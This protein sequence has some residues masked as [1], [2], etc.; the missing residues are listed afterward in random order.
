MD[1]FY[2]PY[3][4]RRD[5]N[6]VGLSELRWFG[7]YSVEVNGVPFDFNLSLIYTFIINTFSAA[8]G[9]RMSMNWPN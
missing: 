7:T 3:G 1:V 6:Y 5:K 2:P 9:K 4:Y 8:S